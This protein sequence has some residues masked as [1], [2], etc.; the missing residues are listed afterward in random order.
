MN[1]VW[2][3][4]EIKTK[5][6]MRPKWLCRAIV[7]LYHQQTVTERIAGET[8]CEN[9]VGFSGCDA[10]RLTYYAKWLQKKGELNG[11]HL[12]IARNMMKK[13]AKQLTRIANGERKE[14]V[15]VPSVKAHRFNVKQK[16]KQFDIP[17]TEDMD[18]DSMKSSPMGEL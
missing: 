7:A 11:K 12:S 9:G 8:R 14:A 1:K 10:R 13:Y 6:F 4:R 2:T 17:I 5:V 15:A 18:L 3:E 16:L